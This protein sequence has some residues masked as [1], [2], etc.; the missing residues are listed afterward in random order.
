MN[1]M[2]HLRVPNGLVEAVL[3]RMKAEQWL[4]IGYRV[5]SDEE[6][7]H[8]LIPI[9]P[10]APPLLDGLTPVYEVV[11]VE[12][13]LDDRPSTDWW[14]Y[15]TDALGEAEVALHGDAWPSNHE[16]IGDMM[17]LR[18]DDAVSQHTK[19]IVNAKMQS[20]PHVRLVMKDRGVQG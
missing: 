6:G 1:V 5:M 12:G 8:R 18:I 4:A 17:I 14:K 15:L 19:A 7:H 20:H 11:A 13:L 2:R 16:F 9:S 10:G 3:G